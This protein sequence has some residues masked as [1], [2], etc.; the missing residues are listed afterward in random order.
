MMSNKLKQV[1]AE[2]QNKISGNY[3]LEV[4]ETSYGTKID[5]HETGKIKVFNWKPVEY[6]EV[7]E[8]VLIF[9]QECF[10]LIVYGNI[11]S[12]ALSNANFLDLSITEED[13][14]F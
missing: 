8:S 4:E 1:V 13:L 14:E 10:E 3:Y 5:L 7:I 6:D 2:L 11:L 9:N 12:E